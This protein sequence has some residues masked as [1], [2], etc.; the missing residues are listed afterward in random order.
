M[1]CCSEVHLQRQCFPNCC[2]TGKC[3][4]RTTQSIKLS[5]HPKWI[6]KTVEVK[7][8]ITLHTKQMTK[9]AVCKRCYKSCVFATGGNTSNLFKHLSLAHPDLY[10]ELRDGQVSASFIIQI[11]LELL[12]THIQMWYSKLIRACVLEPVKFWSRN[13]CTCISYNWILSELEF[14]NFAILILVSIISCEF[15]C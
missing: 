8:G 9:V 11:E 15:F 14:S 1:P 4:T 2:A 5:T 10:R 6:K 13:I 7:Y 3:D 12:F